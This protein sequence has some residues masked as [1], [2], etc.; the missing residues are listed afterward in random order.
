ML[1]MFCN[2]IF[3]IYIFEFIFIIVNSVKNQEKHTKNQIEWGYFTLNNDMSRSMMWPWTWR[4]V[5]QKIGLDEWIRLYKQGMNEKCHLSNKRMNGEIREMDEESSKQA[6]DETPGH[7]ESGPHSLTHL[8]ALLRFPSLPSDSFLNN[9]LRS[10]FFAHRTDQV[11]HRS[12][13]VCDSQHV[14]A[15]FQLFR[16]GSGTVE[17][18]DSTTAESRDCFMRTDDMYNQRTVTGPCVENRFTLSVE[19]IGKP[20]RLNWRPDCNFEGLSERLWSSTR[21]LILLQLM[22]CRFVLGYCGGGGVERTALTKW[23]WSDVGVNG[24]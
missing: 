10:R 14:V 23:A 4:R 5:S 8:P 17:F 21:T 24:F 9:A 20:H 12:F 6:Y 15:F 1:I 22:Y 16:S 18:G 13:G 19:A 11:D 2:K 7:L 3:F